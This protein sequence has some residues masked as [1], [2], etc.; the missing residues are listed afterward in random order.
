MSKRTLKRNKAGS[1][2][3][4]LSQT[5]GIYNALLRTTMQSYILDH[6]RV[7]GRTVTWRLEQSQRRSMF[8][9]GF[10]SDVG[11]S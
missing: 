6:V 4:D 10:K 9:G 2:N 8:I 11:I 5:F 3:M 1:N 7:S